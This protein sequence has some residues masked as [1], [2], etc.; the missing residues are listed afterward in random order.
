MADYTSIKR[1]KP[2]H[3]MP[4]DVGTIHLVGIGGIGMSGIAEILHNLGYQV[5]GSDV[6]ENANVERLRAMNIPVM[7]GHAPENV[8]EASVVVKSSA[9][10]L[11]NP[12]IVAARE[13]SIPVLKRSEMLAEITRLKATIAV[14]GTHGKTTTTSLVAKMLDS[15]GLDPTVI[16]GGIINAYGT[17][18]RVGDGEWLVAEADESDGTFIRI[19]S[20]VGIIT[21]MDPEHLDHWGTYDALREAFA[22]FIDRL[23]FYGFA[24]LCADHPDVKALADA[25]TDR[26]ILRYG[27]KE[28]SLDL[29]AVNLRTTVEGTVFDLEL[30][31]RMCEGGEDCVIKDISLSLTGEHNVL[32]A[33]AAIAVA[34]ELKVDRKAI[35]SAFCNFAGV[36]RRFSKAGEI[37]GVTIID[38]YGHHPTEIKAT[39]KA[40]REVISHSK[41]NKGKV[42]AVVQPHRYSRLERLFVEFCGCFG[43]ADKVI[44]SDVYAAGEQPIEGVD[45]DALVAALNNHGREAFALSSPEALPSMIHEHAETGDMVVC[46]GAGSITQWANNLP[47]ALEKFYDQ[48]VAV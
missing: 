21:N 25:V 19:P 33:L 5:S 47:Q 8:E 40:A 41:D 42:I 38:D 46:L 13:A 20:T 14:A 1:F 3:S 29:R 43:D 15:A 35:T 2:S 45:R 26:R 48:K 10:P 18:A 44:V 17:N 6:A 32:N 36:K 34:L 22:T 39:L 30:S 4:F 28:A 24:V 23:P 7:I 37:N 9:V 16:N 27:M 31:E 11:T 12:E